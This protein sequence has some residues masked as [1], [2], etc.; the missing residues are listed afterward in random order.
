MIDAEKTS[1]DS[2]LSLTACAV[3]AL[4]AIAAGILVFGATFLLI[5][6]PIAACVA[7]AYRIHNTGL[8]KRNELVE[9]ANR[10][11]QTTVEVLATAVDARDKIGTGHVRR[12]QIYALGL[13][14]A[15]GMSQDSLD[16]LRL[17]SLL[18]DI[19]K[20]AIPDHILSKPDSLTP[21]EIEKVKTH[22][23]IGASIL[24]E[25][26][27]P[28]PV[29]PIVRYHH[30]SWDGTG[31]P[32][33]LKGNRIPLGA[34]IL[35]IA[36]TYDALRSERPFRKPMSRN[37]ARTHISNLA[38]S[39]FDPDLVQHFLK[40][41]TRFEV[42][43]AAAGVDYPKEVA[44]QRRAIEG[45][46]Y[47]ERIQSANRE[48]FALFELVREFGESDSLGAMLKLFVAK[49]GELMP[50][51][52][53][54]VYLLH[55]GNEFAS[56]AEVSGQNAD[57]FMSKR[58]R[59]G[60]GATG[61]VLKNL[62]PVVNVNPDLD[63]SISQ[64]DLVQ[65]YQTMAS[66]PLISESGLVGAVS[67]YTSAIN[68][69]EDEHI[70]ILTT[71]ADIAARAIEKL[72]THARTRAHAMTD[73][74]TGLPNARSLQVQFEREVARADRSNSNF[75]VIMLDLDGFKGVNDT[76]GHKVGD[77]MLREVGEV[78]YSQLREYD[79]LARYGG[80]EFIALVPDMTDLDVA[81]LC[82]RIEQAVRAFRLGVK[83]G[84]SAS[85]GV[86]LGAAAFPEK[87]ESLD[88]L[89]V[90]ADRAMYARKT[91]R[92]NRELMR[93][94]H[95]PEIDDL[96]SALS[97]LPEAAPGGLIVELDESAVLID[98]VN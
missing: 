74:M 69:Y 79:F 94:T 53:C 49:L 7:A 42:E 32:S 21:A 56:V 1:K 39:R 13:G 24:E 89:V 19:G 54:A 20:L 96:R 51:D 12:T 63:F 84:R 67:I 43:I 40:N 68:E 37:E 23:T 30:E 70:R 75:Q 77:Q 97:R 65:E 55:E 26:E 14:R 27:F 73:T 52:T 80:D 8:Q 3:I 59:V 5:L 38:G 50:T 60:E 44:P 34:R 81:E 45:K 95:A 11:N 29:V 87:G 93:E 61:I 18:H 71:I 25:I 86:S 33:A 88:Q 76:F 22:C 62:E 98:S 78:I 66:V 15:V 10:L 4:V 9:S 46:S 92:K 64:F 58:V 90:A 35:A 36:D 41:L 47:V 2:I 31:Y 17:G 16:A 72:Q 48:V 85:V 83:G 57:I 28:Y 6:I 91:D 82:E